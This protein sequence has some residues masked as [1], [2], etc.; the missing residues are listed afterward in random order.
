MDDLKE[1]STKFELEEGKTDGA[2]MVINITWIG[3]TLYFDKNN[4][5]VQLKHKVEIPT[6]RKS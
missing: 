6:P 5:H 3:H 2:T 1:I 4:F